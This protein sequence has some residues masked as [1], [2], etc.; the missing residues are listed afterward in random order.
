M[1][2]PIRVSST[3]CDFPD[4]M[5]SQQLPRHRK[6]SGSAIIA[7][8]SLTNALPKLWHGGAD[9][10]LCDEALVF[11]LVKLVVV[12]PDSPHSHHIN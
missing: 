8:S 1:V 2:G 4:T 12:L 3:A 7:P 10:G 5:M 9:E 11:K 6:R